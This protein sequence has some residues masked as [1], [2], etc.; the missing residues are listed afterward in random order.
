[1]SDLIHEGGE[2]PESVIGHPAPKSRRFR[3]HVT[4]VML[5]SRKRRR[6]QRVVTTKATGAP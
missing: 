4:I 1:M 3:F 6:R 2:K 5:G